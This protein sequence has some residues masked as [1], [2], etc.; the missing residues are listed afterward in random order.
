MLTLSAVTPM[1]TTCLVLEGNICA[2]PSAHVHLH[3][4]SAESTQYNGPACRS[5]ESHGSWQCVLKGRVCFSSLFIYFMVL[6]LKP[7]SIAASPVSEALARRSGLDH[8]CLADDQPV[9][10]A[11]IL[12]SIIN[13]VHLDRKEGKEKKQQKAKLATVQRREAAAEVF[14]L[15]LPLMQA[16][17]SICTAVLQPL[18][19]Q[20]SRG[21]LLVELRRK[22]ALLASSSNPRARWGWEARSLCSRH[23]QVACTGNRQR[24]CKCAIPF[25]LRV[26][27]SAPLGLQPFPH[28]TCA[29]RSWLLCMRPL[30]NADCIQLET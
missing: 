13:S 29:L 18:H 16:A 26:S 12:F 30:F 2:A 20:S 14:L 27:S 22:L 25:A 21:S 4:K 23:R 9:T 1:C 6:F 11:G 5:L 24:P 10:V 28:L 3:F 8:W 7:A 15:I 19:S 17:V